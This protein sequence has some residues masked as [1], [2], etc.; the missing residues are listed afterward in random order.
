MAGSHWFSGDYSYDILK[1]PYNVIGNAIGYFML[2]LFGPQSLEFYIMLRNVLRENIIFATI[3]FFLSFFVIAKVG[4]II[5][6]RLSSEEKKIIIFGFLFFIISLLP[7]LG[8]GNISSRY[9]YL[10]SIGFVIVFVV[11]VKKAFSYLLSIS[12]KYTTFVIVILISMIFGSIQ[13]FQLQNLHTD[14]NVAG[15]KTQRFLISFERIYKDYWVDKRM[16]FYF[17]D[18]PIKNGEA[19]VFPVGLNDALWFVLPNKEHLL[20]QVGSVEEAFS[21]ISDPKNSSVF[22]FDA[23]GRI[24][25]YQKRA[26]GSIVP[27]E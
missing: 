4:K 9:S 26:D 8:L 25:E 17:V 22:R 14:W 21:R 5:L 20:D 1:L 6:K 24:H 12:D 18:V 16:H 19:W 11:F 13:L 7:F 3:G 15:E 2:D 23:D 10:S 27:I